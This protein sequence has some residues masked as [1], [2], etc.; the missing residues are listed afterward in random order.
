[1]RVGELLTPV[2]AAMRR[3][4]LEGDYIRADETP[5]GVQMHDVDLVGL[6][7]EHIP[8]DDASFDC[9]VVTYTLCSVPDPVTALKEMRRVLKTGGR[10]LFCE[11]GRAPDEKRASLARSADPVLEKHRRGVSSQSG[12]RRTYQ[13]SG[14]SR[15]GTCRPCTCQAPDP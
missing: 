12:H 8:L 3:E 13:R 14:V 9:V 2:V 11:H 5:V 15:A 1:M 4:L 7:A 6:S 10:F